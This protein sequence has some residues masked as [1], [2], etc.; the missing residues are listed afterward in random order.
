MKALIIV[1]IIVQVSLC[2]GGTAVTHTLTGFNDVYGD[3]IVIVSSKVD[4]NGKKEGCRMRK[5]VLHALAALDADGSLELNM[6]DDKQTYKNWNPANVQAVSKASFLA[7]N[8]YPKSPIPEK[9]VLDTCMVNILI[10]D[11]DALDR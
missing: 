8:S 4:S 6:I 10:G 7:V 2:T 5:D 11:G 3:W 9:E 1:A